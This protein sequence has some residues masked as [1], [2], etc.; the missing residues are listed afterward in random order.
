MGLETI[1]PLIHR[2]VAARQSTNRLLYISGLTGAGKTTLSRVLSERQS[3]E[4]HSEFIEKIPLEFINTNSKSPVT[5]QLKAQ[6]WV[7]AQHQQKNE[8]IAHSQTSRIIAD[9]SW[10]DAIAYGALYSPEVLAHTVERVQSIAWVSGLFVFLI[11]EKDI[12]KS[13]LVTRWGISEEDWQMR[14]NKDIDDLITI[15]KNIAAMTGSALLDSTHASAEEI[16]DQVSVLW[17]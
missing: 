14:W 8:L 9:R 17:R 5:E 10:L 16:G 2:L 12:I 13:R 3:A 15:Y 7:I 11:A 4:L 1:Q 6:D